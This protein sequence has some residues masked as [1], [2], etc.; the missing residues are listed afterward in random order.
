VD[1]L[2]QILGAFVDNPGT[3]GLIVSIVGAL[4]LIGW[5]ISAVT[6]TKVDDSIFGFLGR[7]LGLK[8]PEEAEASEEA[9]A[10][11]SEPLMRERPMVD[12]ADP[13]KPRRLDG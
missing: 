4:V 1:I 13:A 11:K 10:A 7:M 6:K 8:G 5:R 12:E 3:V 2:T 9:A